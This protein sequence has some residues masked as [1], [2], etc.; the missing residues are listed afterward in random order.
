MDKIKCPKYHALK[1]GKK[2]KDI[3]LS[4]IFKL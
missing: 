2:K 3:W 4:L 1:G